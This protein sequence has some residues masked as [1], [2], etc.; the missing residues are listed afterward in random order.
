[1][2]PDECFGVWMA[3]NFLAKFTILKGKIHPTLFK[4]HNHIMASTYHSWTCF[5]MMAGMMEFRYLSVLQKCLP[6]Y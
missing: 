4:F 1:M 5:L 6:T 2:L 3:S